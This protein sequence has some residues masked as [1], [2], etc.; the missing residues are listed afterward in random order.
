MYK[1]KV[2]SR[3]Q[4]RCTKS[5]ENLNCLSATKIEGATLKNSSSRQPAKTTEATTGIISPLSA[6]LLPQ[7]PYHSPEY[8]SRWRLPLCQQSFELRIL[9][10][11]NGNY[12]RFG[13]THHG[14]I[15]GHGLLSSTHSSVSQLRI[16]IA[17]RLYCKNA[18]RQPRGTMNNKIM[19]LVVSFVP[20]REKISERSEDKLN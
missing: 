6:F 13:Q 11:L 20:A 9:D 10:I 19:G 8:C 15:Y 17:A 12:F 2:I 4:N 1:W 7:N 16:K 3:A 5:T 14:R 18:K